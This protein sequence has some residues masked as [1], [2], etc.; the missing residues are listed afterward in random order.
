M[1]GDECIE[2][3]SNNNDH[4]FDLKGNMKQTLPLVEHI[5][6]NTYIMM[7]LCQIITIILSSITVSTELT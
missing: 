1:T 7:H 5:C 6:M 2:A 4:V 3:L